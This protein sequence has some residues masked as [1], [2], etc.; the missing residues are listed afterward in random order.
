MKSIQLSNLKF[1]SWRLWLLIAVVVIA[2]VALWL[3]GPISQDSSYHAFADQRTLFGIA[4]FWNVVSNLPFLIVGS[5]GLAL[6]FRHRLNNSTAY[7]RPAYTIFF[8]ALVLV[9]LGSAYYHF[10]PNN[11][12]L[13]WDRLPMTV[14]FMAFFAT[15]I[16]EHIR[17]ISLRRILVPLI[18]LGIGS[19]VW[20]QLNGDLRPY[21]LVQFLPILLIPAVLILF[22]S[23][24]RGT[25]LIWAVLAFYAVAKAFEFFDESIYIAIGFS[26]HSLKHIAAAMG[27]YFVA[28]LFKRQNS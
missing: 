3:H 18:L 2:I 6:L 20:W 25:A 7:T 26:G 8:S 27:V 15:I 9:A 11:A 21:V 13:F 23:Q 14:A 22:P 10:N 24:K 28:L 4:H 16:S 5:Y 19:V 17:C 1:I 12:T